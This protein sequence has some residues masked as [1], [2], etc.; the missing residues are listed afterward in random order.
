MPFPIEF[1]LFGL[2]LAGIALFH[3]RALAISLGGLFAILAYQGAF[4]A[5]PTG[6]GADALLEH[7]GHEW[8]IVTN[9]LLLLLGFELLANHFERS[10]V[11]DHLPA[12]CRPAGWGPRPPCHDLHPL[13]LS[14]QYRRC[15][16]GRRHGAP[17]ST[18]AG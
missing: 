4:S 16:T 15:R 8:V 10:N 14:R 18:R 6:S 13:R 3:K 2:M 17:K 12:I 7:L 9:L 5:F 1:V 11:S